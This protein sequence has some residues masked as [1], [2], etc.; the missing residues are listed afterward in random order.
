MQEG[1]YRELAEQEG[2]FQQ[3]LSYQV[4]SDPDGEKHGTRA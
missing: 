4:T 3:L 1:T 2:L